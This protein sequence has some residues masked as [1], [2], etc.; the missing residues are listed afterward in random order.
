MAHAKF[1]AS[2]FDIGR[3]LIRVDISRA[4]DGTFARPSRGKARNRGGSSLG[5]PAGGARFP[6]FRFFP[7]RIYC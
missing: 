4:M 7:I 2:I 1:R 3:V 5:G 6:F